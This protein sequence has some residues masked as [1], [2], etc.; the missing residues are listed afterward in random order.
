MAP[1][2]IGGKEGPEGE[3]VIVAGRDE[4]S[5]HARP[6]LLRNAV[7]NTIVYKLSR[8]RLLESQALV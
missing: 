3:E 1:R 2:K 6:R 4:Q 5:G 7:T 8:K